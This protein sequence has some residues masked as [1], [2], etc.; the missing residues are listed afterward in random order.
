MGPHYVNLLFVMSVINSGSGCLF[1]LVI[2]WR[3]FLVVKYK[4]YCFVIDQV[5]IIIFL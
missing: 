2:A 4:I 1:F 3:I 5:A